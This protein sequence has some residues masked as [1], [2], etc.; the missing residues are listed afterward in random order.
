M[1]L[2]VGGREISISPQQIW[3]Q[4]G[5]AEVYELGFQALKIYKPPDHL[6][7]LTQIERDGAEF[8]IREHQTKLPAFPK[9]IPK[10]IVAPDDL[11]YDSH[12]L[13]AGYTMPLVTSAEPLMGFSEKTSRSPNLSNNQILDVF[14]NLHRLIAATHKAAIVV[15][16]FNDLNVLVDRSDN[17]HLID[18]DSFQYGSFLSR[19]FTSI[20]VDPL[21]C[22]PKAKKLQLSLPHNEDSDWYAFAVMLMRS[23]LCVGPYGGVYRPKSSSVKVTEPERPLYR[24]TVFNPDTRYPKPAMPLHVLPDSLLEQF[25]RIFEKDKRGVFPEN[26]LAIRWT[27]CLKCGTEHAR[28]TCPICQQMSPTLKQTTVIRGNVTCVSVFRTKGAIL[29]ASVFKDNLLWLFEENGVMKREDGH[30]LM[31]QLESYRYRLMPGYT[32]KGRQHLISAERKLGSSTGFESYRQTDSYDSLSVYDINSSHT[33][34]LSNGRL[35]HSD[36][37]E[38]IHIGDILQNKTLFWVGEKF[39]FG[40]YQAGRMTVGFVFD[41][42]RK[43]INDSVEIQAIRGQLLD[44]TCF[45]ANDRCW[46]IMSIDEGGN[47]VNKCLVINRKGQVEAQA[48]ANHNDGWCRY[49]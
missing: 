49:K 5:E 24:L 33:Y 22:E 11:A 17:C 21:L 42:E 7:F 19:M 34:W 10:G 43:G 29:H 36:E 31:A 3:K 12:G 23:L 32:L 30:K 39:G 26:Q 6:H 15:G 44:S 38:D 20:F 25:Q 13:I 37:F 2:T 16:D 28:K 27:K 41:A 35:M 46:F 14:V 1:N 8:R 47:R 4:G 9:N 18:A 45:F 40:F 48:E